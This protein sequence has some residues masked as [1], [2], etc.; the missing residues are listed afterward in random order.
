M[1]VIPDARQ[2]KIA[3][4]RYMS[5]ISRLPYPGAFQFIHDNF[6]EIV[7]HDFIVKHKPFLN[8]YE[9]A[10]IAN[11]IAMFGKTKSRSKPVFN[12][13]PAL[14]GLKKLW[15]LTDKASAYSDNPDYEAS[16]ALR[17]VYQQIPY[18]LHPLRVLRVC[19]LMSNLVAAP[20]VS[21]CIEKHTGIPAADFMTTSM[22]LLETFSSECIRP[23]SFLLGCADKANIRA[24]LAQLSANRPKRLAFHRSELRRD[25]LTEKL[26]EINSLLRFPLIKDEYQYFA[27]YPELIGYASTRG[28]FFRLSKEAGSD[29]R[30][31][32]ARALENETARLL[33][34]V[35]PDAEIL[36][37]KDDRSLGWKGKTN[38]V[39]LIFGENALLIECK[40]SGLFVE[41]KLTAAPE[42]I[43][44]DVK[45]QIADGDERR[46]LFQ[47]HDKIEAIRSAKLP[48]KLMAKYAGVKSFFPV[49]LLFDA[50][51]HANNP[52]MIGNIIRDALSA[53]GVQD[54]RYQIWHLEEL[55]WLAEFAGASL[56]DWTQEK[57][58]PRNCDFSLNTFI[59][60][61]AGLTLLTPPM[62]M[63][64]DSRAFAILKRISDMESET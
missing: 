7:A 49:L 44:A 6:C 47:L 39:T 51:E 40:L 14:N 41:A 21:A 26:Y 27:P 55:S 11:H 46:G 15:S 4:Q 17:W 9:V 54:F 60:R 56:L 12:F 37:E 36:T 22:I 32:F 30:E 59:A 58:S 61:K 1:E 5:E 43:I 33:R 45:K 48:P 23:D 50:I 18:H 35:L 42:A 31:P 10:M 28:L 57:F 29:F 24:T 25:N 3:F 62:Y 16:F 38:D 53:C 2:L 13:T 64:I 34:S 63:P 19:S 8:P 52:L 20:D